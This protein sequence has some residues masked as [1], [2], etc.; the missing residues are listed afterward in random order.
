MLFENKIDEINANL[1]IKDHKIEALQI[2]NQEAVEELNK[3][4]QTNN[5]PQKLC[6]KPFQIVNLYPQ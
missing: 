5:F 4:R 3:W 1:T 6:S 2:K